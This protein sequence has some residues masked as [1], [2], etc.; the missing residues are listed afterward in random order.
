MLRFIISGRGFRKVCGQ[1][2]NKIIEYLVG[3]NNQFHARIQSHIGRSG[4]NNVVSMNN[5][6]NMNRTH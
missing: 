2:I 4:P 6:G 3:K 1:F 5:M